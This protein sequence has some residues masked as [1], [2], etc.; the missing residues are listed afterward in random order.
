MFV[1]PGAAE[2]KPGQ[3]PGNK[4]GQYPGNKPGQYPYFR[5]TAPEIGILSLVC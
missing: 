4:P 1:S 5:Q 3:Y 2:N